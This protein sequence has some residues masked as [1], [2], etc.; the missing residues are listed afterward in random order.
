MDK[1]N[2]DK[3]FTVMFF[4]NEIKAQ[5]AYFNQLEAKLS[6]LNNE[7]MKTI[8]KIVE[9]YYGKDDDIIFDRGDF[10]I[11]R[12]INMLFS[13]V[14]S[15]LQST[16]TK[17]DYLNTIALSGFGIDSFDLTDQEKEQFRSLCGEAGSCLFASVKDENGKDTLRIKDQMLFDIIKQRSF[18]QVPKDQKELR[19]LFNVYL[20]SY[21]EEHK[22]QEKEKQDAERR[23]KQAEREEAHEKQLSESYGKKDAAQPSPEDT[24]GRGS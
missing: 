9:K 24:E 19:E 17:I 5:L 14:M 8:S 23:K 3:P 1:E 2:K 6:E 13:S 4:S 12:Q 22:R 21:N 18:D 7:N 10:A 20:V 11:I 16:V 15:D